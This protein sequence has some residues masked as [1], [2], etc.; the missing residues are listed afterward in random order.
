MN[1]LRNELAL[2]SE[3]LKEFHLP[4][5]QEL[6]DLD[7][8]M[9]QVIQ[10]VDQY[11]M[12]VIQ[13]DKHPL[14]TP[15]MVNNYVKKDLIP[16]PVKK[17]YQRKHLAFLIA[18]TLLKQVITIPEIKSGILFQGKVSGIREA[19]DLFC[20]EQEYAIQFITNQ[21]KL[22][23]FEGEISTELDLVAV[24]AATRSFANKLLAEKM[25]SLQAKYILN[26]EKSYE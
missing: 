12:P 4:R 13:T 5:W 21:A 2:W 10:L 20:N 9:D 16:A 23:S 18:I 22:T 3:T 1:E 19:Y 17:R 25:I 11:L 8:Y 26:G 7:L 14:L 6:P 15:A 24:Q